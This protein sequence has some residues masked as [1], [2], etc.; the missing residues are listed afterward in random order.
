MFKMKKKLK[1]MK[2]KRK[3]ERKEKKVTEEVTVAPSI[4]NVTVD[5]DEGEETEDVVQF[6]DVDVL[7]FIIHIEF[8]IFNSNVF[9]ILKFVP[10]ICILVPP[11]IGPFYFILILILFYFILLILFFD[12]KEKK[13]KKEKKKKTFVGENVVIV[14]FGKYEK[15]VW[16]ESENPLIV[17]ESLPVFVVPVDPV[18]HLRV[19]VS[20]KV[21]LT[22]TTP[23]I[24]IV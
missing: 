16:D 3:E 18:V 1:W 6:N 15:S 20:M 9:P 11:D 10:L 2:E 19:V 23:P 17:K 13:E 21:G 8:P 12:Q 14:G 22:Q 7:E 24:V 5:V 4:V